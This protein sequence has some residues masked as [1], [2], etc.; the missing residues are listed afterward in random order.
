MKAKRLTASILIVLFLAFAIVSAF[1]YDRSAEVGIICYEGSYAEEYAKEHDIVCVPIFDSEAYIGILNL[2]HFDY[3]FDGEIVSYKGESEKIAIPTDI[4]GTRITKVHEKAFES[5]KNLETIYLPKSIETFEPKTLDGVTVY[6]Y[7]DT[8]LYK[9]LSKDESVTYEIKT[10]A[11]S[12]YVDFYSSDIPFA[13][14]EI[15]GKTIEIDAYYAELPNV[16]IPESIDGKIVTSIAFDAL[17][18]GVETMVIPS[19]VVNIE[20]KLYQ[21]RYDIF[22]LIALLMALLG[23]ALA[24]VLVLVLDVSSKEKM[25]L[26]VSQF[27]TTYLLGVAS[28]VLSAGYL[29][30]DAVPTVAF[31]ALFAIVCVVAV[32]SII[33]AKTAVSLVEGIDE[34]VEGKIALLKTL[35]ADAE[36]VMEIAKTAELK[37]E[38]KRVYEALRYS[39]PVSSEALA[40]VETRIQ[41]ELTSF[42]EAVAT[43]DVALTQS[44]A[45]ELL[46]LIDNRNKKCKAMK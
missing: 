32:I 44:V 16:I 28:I 23:T 4:E 14:N 6:L 1:F 33:K 9:T 27:K 25:F 41:S 46:D 37:A 43:E 24:V 5:A 39:D 38:A 34:K 17:A 42:A 10:V 7:E 31:Y 20:G 13:Y 40:D 19:T 15:S 29:F 26:R 2:E 45:G 3:N 22:F 21:N 36:C 30:V 11:D 18:D 35:I 8:E 12:Y